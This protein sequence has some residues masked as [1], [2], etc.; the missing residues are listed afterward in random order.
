MPRKLELK[1]EILA[2]L[3]PDE[4]NAVNAGVPTQVLSYNLAICAALSLNELTGCLVYTCGNGCTGT[5]T[6]QKG[7]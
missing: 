1:K 4:L 3:T 7:E 5:S 2:E 6:A